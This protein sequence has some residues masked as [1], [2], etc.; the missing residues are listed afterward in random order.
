MLGK[1]SIS[2]DLGYDGPEDCSLE[3]FVARVDKD[4]DLVLMMEYLDYG[5]VLL[6]EI[7]GLEY[8][9]VANVVI[10]EKEKTLTTDSSDGQENHEEN[11]LRQKAYKWSNI[12]TALY[13]H[14][15]QTFWSKIK[16]YNITPQKVEN[17]RT[18]RTKISS[19]CIANK[20]SN[21]ALIPK[22]FRPWVPSGIGRV[23]TYILSEYGNESDFC[24]SLIRPEL[25]FAQR[26]RVKQGWPMLAKYFVNGY[27]KEEWSDERLEKFLGLEG[28]NLTTW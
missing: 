27:S 23:S 10:N 1:N 18:Y 9:D 2:W 20:T 28:Y 17:F 19:T 25:S 14:F 12:D 26:L 24:K 22:E 11:D 6:K 8:S 5:L 15:N 4:F 21:M 16:S 3:E 13:N 7:L